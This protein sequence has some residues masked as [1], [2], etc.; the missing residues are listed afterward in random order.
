MTGLSVP[1]AP[2]KIVPFHCQPIIITGQDSDAPNN[3]KY[4]CNLPRRQPGGGCYT[5]TGFRTR[6]SWPV[7]AT[8]LALR[9]PRLALRPVKRQISYLPSLSGWYWA[10]LASALSRSLLARAV[11][12]VCFI[13][14]VWFI[15]HMVMWLTSV[16]FRSR[17]HLQFFPHSPII[18]ILIHF[19]TLRLCY[20][21]IASWWPQYRRPQKST[22]DLRWRRFLRVSRSTPQ[23]I[24]FV[25]LHRFLITIVL[26]HLRI[27]KSPES[28][29]TFPLLC[30]YHVHWERI[31]KDLRVLQTIRREGAYSKH[32]ARG[33]KSMNICYL[34][35][36]D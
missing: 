24:L 31:T 28:T 30:H 27:Q 17:L 20:L 25:L 19:P 35:W 29:Q 33:W 12:F 34:P 32:V 5:T 10:F 6:P 7:V 26:L 13:C 22:R 21:I 15:C 9:C 1:S 36:F 23:N 8:H 16:N 18:P 4:L 11:G 14:L 2:S 3:I